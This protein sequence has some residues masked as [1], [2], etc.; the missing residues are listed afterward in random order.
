M[1]KKKAAPG[2]E[3]VRE[4]NENPLSAEEMLGLARKCGALE[5]GERGMD[6]HMFAALRHF[7]FDGDSQKLVLSAMFRLEALMRLVAAGDLPGWTKSDETGQEF[8]RAALFI[9]AGQAPL[10]LRDGRAQFRREDILER[11]FQVSKRRD[12]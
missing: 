6:G 4:A 8:T 1:A 2:A 7:G 12:E 11:A 3:F 5:P 10:E 9:A